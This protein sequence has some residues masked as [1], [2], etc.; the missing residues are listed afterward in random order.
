MVANLK[1]H[2]GEVVVS[3]GTPFKDTGGNVR[4]VFW[5]NDPPTRSVSRYPMIDIR[6]ETRGHANHT[7]LEWA[8]VTLEIKQETTQG[9]HGEGQLKGK[10]GTPGLHDI[11]QALIAAIGQLHPGST[12]A[13]PGNFARVPSNDSPPSSDGNITTTVVAFDTGPL[14]MS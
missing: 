5:T 9:P 6:T 7:A 12:P 8:S 4:G 13:M 11:R 10:H 3:G 14:T 1:T 2:I